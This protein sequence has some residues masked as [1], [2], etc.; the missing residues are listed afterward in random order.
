MTIQREQGQFPL[1]EANQLVAGLMK[2]NPKT[3]WLDFLISISL[4]WAGFALALMNPWVS[5]AGIAGL[6]LSTFALYR[7]V[8]FTHE[9]TH[10]KTGTFKVFRFVWN[11]LCGFALL[12]PAFT[13]HGVHRHHHV[14]DVYGTKAD[15]EYLPF[16]TSHPFGLIGYM[17]LIFILPGFFVVR[18]MVLAPLSWALPPLRRLVWSRLSS[19]TIDPAYIRPM[20]GAKDPKFLWAAQE[21]MAFAYGWVACALVW[22][23]WLPAKAL[24]L[25]YAIAVLIFFLNSLRTLAAHAYRN[26][27]EEQ[28]TVP[29]QF[30]DSVDIPGH[31]VLTTLWAPV[32]LRFHAT[33]H[34][35]PRMPYHNLPRAYDI[36][37]DGLSDNTMFLLASRKSLAHALVRIWKD[38]AQA[39]R[40][41]KAQPAE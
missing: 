15:G 37:R 20:P 3:Y 13:Y 30:L 23:G 6:V 28:L 19:L 41:R 16:G 27:G 11:I 14:H 34:L 22:F 31:P 2:P 38:A 21:F 9:L 18:F 39:N 1:M 36:L 5:W 17:L 40:T 32:G 24:V 33:H 10:L 12:I 29:E 35:F 25:W 4:G 8:L 26:S 7:A